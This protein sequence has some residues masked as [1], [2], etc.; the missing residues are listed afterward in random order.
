MHLQRFKGLIVL[1]GKDPQFRLFIIQNSFAEKEIVET[2]LQF[3][4]SDLD[5]NF[6][7][8]ISYRSCT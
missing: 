1:G 3:V 6:N 7:E 2:L 5:E 4:S 8:K